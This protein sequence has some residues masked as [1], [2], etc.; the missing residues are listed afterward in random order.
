M[1]I[2]T[3]K[4][5]TVEGIEGV[6]KS[7][8]IKKIHKFLQNSEIEHILTREPGGTEIAENIRTVMLQ[9]YEETMCHETE[10]LL[11]F[12]G[13][14]QHLH[15]VIRPA[16]EKGQWVICDRFT[17]AT[18]AYQGG[19]RKIPATKI[20]FLKNWVHP[21]LMPD[22]TLLLHAPVEVALSRA[23]GRASPDRIELEKKAFFEDTQNVYFELAKHSPERFKLINANQSPKHVYENLKAIL[24]EYLSHAK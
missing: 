7:T 14:A 19:G 10:L 4:F 21:D 15:Q 13:R 6:G 12:A 20:E 1:S 22:L 16:L 17:D 23:K 5:I 3:A 8:L 18:F 24:N 2:K 11:A 9:H